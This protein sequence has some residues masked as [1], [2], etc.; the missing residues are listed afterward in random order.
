MKEKRLDHVDDHM[1][2]ASAD[3]EAELYYSVPFELA[4]G[5][6]ALAPVPP[7]VDLE[8]TNVCDLAC[9]FCETLVMK[10]K[11]GMMSLELFKKIIDECDAIG[12][13]SCKINGWGESLL[14][15]QLCNMV[16][17]A[18]THSKLILQFNTNANRLTP[19]IS[20]R[21]VS[22]GLDRLTVSIDGITKETYE[23]LRVKGSYE[24]VF[25][26]VHDLLDIK[27][28]LNTNYPHLTVQIIRTTE[29]ATEIEPFVEYWKNHAD[30]VTV[31]NIGITVTESVLRFSL[32]ERSAQGRK[33]CEQPW[34][35]LFVNWNG[36]V[37]VC[38]SDFDGVL[39]IGNIDETSLLDLWHGE[40]LTQLRRRHAA[41]DFDGLICKTCTETRRYSDGA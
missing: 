5:G 3:R 33:A 10:R 30:Q 22:A 25:R 1:I 14:N 35:R 29:N 17:Y 15:K 18:K 12:V 36:E 19:K 32:R 16:D 38:C 23:K 6:Y 21:L 41:R 27:K 28:Q 20:R 2:V 4:D 24:D 37:T 9:E 34:Q 7:H 13:K 26:N 39:A 31:T 8:L 11:P 40:K